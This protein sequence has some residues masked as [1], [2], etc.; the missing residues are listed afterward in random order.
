MD[1][2]DIEF[3]KSLQHEMNTQDHVCQA[4]PRFWVVQGT[5]KEYGIESGYSDG[6]TLS[7]TDNET[8]L[9]NMK[10]ICEYLIENNEENLYGFEYDEFSDSISYTDDEGEE[11][12]LS[13]FD[14]VLNFLDDDNYYIA[15]YRNVDK[16][17]ENTM[18]L[19]NAECKAH[20]KANYYHYPDDAHSYAMTAWR[21]PEVE[22]LWKILQTTNWGEI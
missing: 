10:D 21:S 16:N 2:K 8:N 1:K 6:A 7:N 20:I 14:D 3:L 22:R 5:V 18:F 12:R 9:E 17:Y 19:T 15:Y 4:N 13:D 11:C